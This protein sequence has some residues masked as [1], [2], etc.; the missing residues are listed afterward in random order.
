MLISVVIPVYNM[1]H[2]LDRCVDSVLKQTFDNME[3]LLVDDGSTDSSAQKC[4]SWA[5]KDAR[6]QVLHQ[7][8]G[9]LSK[10]RNTGIAHADG[11]FL[12]FVD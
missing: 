8:N 10:A 7:P 2:T 1:Q 6:V 3:V 9:G 11:D 4:D 12:A 5:E